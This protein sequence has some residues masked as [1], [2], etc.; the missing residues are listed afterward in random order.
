MAGTGSLFSSP[1]WTR[2]SAIVQAVARLGFDLKIPTL[3]EGVETEAQRE[4]LRKEG[5]REM[6]GHLVSRPVP[7]TEINALLNAYRNGW[8]AKEYPLSA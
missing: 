7:A 5:Y 8:P 3:A 4:L 2:S 1:A 6:Q